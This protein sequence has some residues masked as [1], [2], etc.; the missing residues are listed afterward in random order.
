MFKRSRIRRPLSLGALLF[1]GV[2]ATAVSL[3][4]ALAQSPAAMSVYRSAGA[5]RGLG[6]GAGSGSFGASDQSAR[7]INA[8]GGGSNN[9]NA[10]RGAYGYASEGMGGMGGAEQEP[11]EWK[12]IEV[13]A[14][15]YVYR[16]HE[17]GKA[18]TSLE[19]YPSEDGADILV[20]SASCDKTAKIWSLEGKYNQETAEWFVTNG[21]ARKTYNPKNK[22]VHH[23]GLTCATFSPDYYYVLTTSY[24]QSGRL[25]TIRNQENTK[26]YLGAKDRLWSIAVGSDGQLV[27]GAC[28]DGRIYI[29]GPLNAEKLGSLPNRKDAYE[30]G[31]DNPD[32]GHEGPVFDVAFSPDGGF[33]ASA[34]ADGT[35]RLW[36]LSLRRQTAVFKVSDDKVYSVR[37]SE[38]GNYLLTASRDKTARI[39]DATNRKEVCRFVGHTGAVRKAIFAGDYVA[40][41]SDDGTARLWSINAEASDN[42]NN[43]NGYGG[44]SMGSMPGVSMGGVSM[45][46]SMGEPGSN[47]RDGESAQGK[48]T[49]KP[50]KPKGTELACFNVTSPTFS[51]AVSSDLVYLVTGSADGLARVWRVP[52]NG[53]YYSESNQNNNGGDSYGGGSTGFGT[54]PMATP[55]STMGGGK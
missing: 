6:G 49:R 50:G 21:R 4:V 37:F 31:G 14:P 18:I 12:S 19:F 44:S 46:G 23:Q 16:G 5:L 34:G 43:R 22:E 28:N 55:A 9:N 48:P 13:K 11:E 41:C 17:E 30:S 52:G 2:V 15:E 25:W 1:A 26:A 20:L 47:G 42:N 45:S 53:R 32:V 7:G 10:N 35:V 29:W 8:Y 54:S 40:T 33:L 51:L 39:F 24:D 38:D 36:N 27:A 3:D